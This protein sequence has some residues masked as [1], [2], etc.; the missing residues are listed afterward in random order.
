MDVYELS[1]EHAAH[2]LSLEEG[3]FLDV[4]AIEIQPAKLTRTFSAFAN[5]DGGEIYVGIDEHASGRDWRGFDNVEA[6]NG[7]IQAL[8]QVAPLGADVEVEFLQT[9]DKPGLLM[10]VIV[11]KSRAIREASDGN[12]YVRRAAQN[13]PVKTSE[14]LAQLKRAKGITSY[15]NETVDADGDAVSNSEVI[16]GFMLEIVPEGEPEV[17]LRKQRLLIDAKPTV[18]GVLL[19]GDEPQAFLP[20]AAVKIY[21]YKS[22]DAEGTRETLAFD[23]IAIE[24]CLYEQIHDAVAKTTELIEGIQILAEHGLEQV[25]Y[26]P[27]ALHEIIT[28]AVIHRDYSFADDVHVRIFDN[29]VEVQ[30][31]GR[32]PAHITPKNILT[33]RF[34]RNAS[35]VRLINK[36]PDPPNKDVGEG[37]NTAFAAMKRLQLRDPVIEEGEN[38]VLVSILHEELA[39]PEQI[40][41]EY[42][43]RNPEIN[44]P[45]A[46]ELTNIDSEYRVR[47]ILARLIN[48]GEVEKVPGKQ[49]R[50]T[51]YRKRRDAGNGQ[52]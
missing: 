6:A 25:Q 7:H 42:L 37:L 30:S 33:E 1:P 36:F 31:P 10:H 46:R 13:L 32:L 24:G 49:S 50:A 40:I 20:K 2:I 45:R 17:W 26:P 44:N 18:A 3:H 48:A 5:S 28:N 29:R 39:S 27:E 38:S 16:I 51:A 23:P 43:D 47:R 9:P 34:A 15:E 12:P 14:A 4:K 21:R 22:S 41:M 35:I 11:L 8:E 52:A 19:F